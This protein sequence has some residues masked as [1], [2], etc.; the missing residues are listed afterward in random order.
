MKDLWRDMFG[1]YDCIILCLLKFSGR[2]CVTQSSW[3]EVSLE[4]NFRPFTCFQGDMYQKL[5]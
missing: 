3:L 1:W 2:V 5:Y 4:F